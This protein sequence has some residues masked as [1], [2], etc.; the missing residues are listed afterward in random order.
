MRSKEFEIA[1]YTNNSTAAAC[2]AFTT[3]SNDSSY[4]FDSLSMLVTSGPDPR[5]FKRR[6]LFTAWFTFSGT[7]PVA[8]SRSERHHR[9]HNG[10]CGSRHKMVVVPSENFRKHNVTRVV[11]TKN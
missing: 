3:S 11:K 8:A 9:R 2:A 6:L 4:L 10:W 1:Q 7:E 5:K